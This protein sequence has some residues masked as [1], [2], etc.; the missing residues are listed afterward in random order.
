MVETKKVKFLYI[1]FLIHQNL[2]GAIIFNINVNQLRFL[3][4]KH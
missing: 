2:K 1:K 3:S 4:T